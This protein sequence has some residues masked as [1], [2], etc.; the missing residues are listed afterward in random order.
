M[1]SH[2]EVLL[3]AMP[4][5]IL[6]L[7]G[8]VFR[9][10]GAIAKEHIDGITRLVYSVLV[11]CFIIDKIL[12]SES[13]KAGSIIFSSIALGF[14]MIAVGI[15]IG[16]LFGWLIGLEKGHGRRTFALASGCQNFGFNA[17]PVVEIL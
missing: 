9:W 2:T 12:G 4:V 3:S 16:Y 5:Y 7:L 10:T 14:G 6:I 13:I 17:A 1:I 8:V 11:P 15:L